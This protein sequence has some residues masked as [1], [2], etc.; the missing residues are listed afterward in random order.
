MEGICSMHQ[1]R[2]E[3]AFT[4]SRQDYNNLFC[5]KHSV[6][7]IE[8]GGT[9]MLTSLM[10]KLSKVEIEKVIVHAKQY[11]E[12][13][14]NLINDLLNCANQIINQINAT[15]KQIFQKI[16][17]QKYYIRECIYI[18]ALKRKSFN[19]KLSEFLLSNQF[20][21]KKHKFRWVGDIVKEIDNNFN[22]Y[23]YSINKDDK[24]RSNFYKESIDQNLYP[25]QKRR[26]GS[27][28]PKAD[29][30]YSIPITTANSNFTE[31]CLQCHTQQEHS[32]LIIGRKS[33]F[34]TDTYLICKNCYFN[35]FNYKLRNSVSYFQYRD[36]R[37]FEFTKL[38]CCNNYKKDDE[39]YGDSD[40]LFY[41]SSCK[42][43]IKL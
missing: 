29:S 5:S 3:A 39:I 6:R 12:L 20:E 15:L 34:D 8:D 13:L 25:F 19:K 14:Q 35:R 2:H 18:K 37:S 9:H 17:I 30:K 23:L 27:A 11:E 36:M 4:C 16:L 40:Y 1:C 7:H 32:K 28:E 41:H 43:R 33:Y 38:N 26:L 10:I 42:P 24:K 21:Y 31:S 22:Y